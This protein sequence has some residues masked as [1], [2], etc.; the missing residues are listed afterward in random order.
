[1]APLVSPPALTSS[2]S[3]FQGK[4]KYKAWEKE[5][6]A[7]TSASDAETKYIALVEKLKS[8]YGFD[9]TKALEAV[10]AK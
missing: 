4:A 9:P 3:C 10:G 7:G 8:Q 5:V 6:Q 1:L 2:P